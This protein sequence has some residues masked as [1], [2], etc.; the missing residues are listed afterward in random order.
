MLIIGGTK[1]NWDRGA[2]SAGAKSGFRAGARPQLL[3]N[4]GFNFNLQPRR[5]LPLKL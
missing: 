1:I 4:D 5:Y 2:V 3:Q